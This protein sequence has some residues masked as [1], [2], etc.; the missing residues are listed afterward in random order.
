MPLIMLACIAASAVGTCATAE[1]TP[2][3]SA[4]GD[5]VFELQ[6]ITASPGR[7]D[8]L[9]AWFRDHQDD[10]LA[11][12]GI[13]SVGFFVPVAEKSDGTLLRLSRYPSRA[14]ADASRRALQADP[15]WRLVDA[16]STDPEALVAKEESIV[17]RPTDF[18]PDFTPTTSAKPRVFELRTYTCPSQKHLA[19]LHERFRDH[20]MG[21]FAKHGM[22]NLVYWSPEGIDSSERKLIYLL[23]HAS[24]DAA[25]ESFAGFRTDPAWL[26][27]KEASETQAGGPLTEKQGG[28]VSQF[29]VGTEYSP[30]R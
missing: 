17:L 7:L 6:I 15:A 10:V 13:A 27:A 26:A 2:R 12:H 21:L 23:G 29:L 3:L 28:V 4:H 9:H 19:L 30:L 16:S 1:T 24:V 8:D 22:E 5:A 14:A 11:R 18:T 20:T 25:K